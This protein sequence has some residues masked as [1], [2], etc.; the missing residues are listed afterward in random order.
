MGLM[1]TLPARIFFSTTSRN[2][3]LNLPGN[4]NGDHGD[5]EINGH[6]SK[7]CRGKQIGRTAHHKNRQKKHIRVRRQ[8]IARA[9]I[10]IQLSR[11][12]DTHPSSGR[13]VSITRSK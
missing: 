8:Q 10:H 1:D 9:L 12:C 2:W 6:R 7:A 5:P 3:V 4:F 13:T 11:S